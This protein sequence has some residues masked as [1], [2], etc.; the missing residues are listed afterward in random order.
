MKR[1]LALLLVVAGSAIAWLVGGESP[2]RSAVD[3]ARAVRPDATRATAEL[4]APAPPTAAVRVAEVVPVVEDE[5]AARKWEGEGMPPDPIEVGPCTL[6]LGVYDLATGEA[7][8]T[9][10]ALWRLDAPATEWWGRGDQLQTRVHVPVEGLAIHDLPE[11]AYRAVVYE[12]RGSSPDPV[13]FDVYAPRTSRAIGVDL[14][15]RYSARILLVDET[16]TPVPEIRRYMGMRS[17]P[18]PTPDWERDRPALFDGPFPYVG[19]GGG[20]MGGLHV[21]RSAE[22]RYD[23]GEYVEAS[24][25]TPRTSTFDIRADGHRCRIHLP[26][27]YAGDLEL[28]GILPSAEFLEGR[29]HAPSEVP[30][31]GIRAWANSIAVPE[32]GADWREVPLEIHATAEGLEPSVTTWRPADGERPWI[33]LEPAR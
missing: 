13:A 32:E 20:A 25:G 29:V 16:G 5:P 4:V 26:A 31:E 30:A 11:G 23:I 10:V 33:V 2:V 19:V 27:D 22:G 17:H 18:D 15:R 7:I 12:Q 1:A 14:P 3:P 9:S 8:A 6:Q 21:Q 24:R 28:I